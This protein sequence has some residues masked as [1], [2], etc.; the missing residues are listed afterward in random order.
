MDEVV[1]STEFGE[2]VD[3]ALHRNR[4]TRRWLMAELDVCGIHFTDTQLSNRCTGYIPFR[5]DE[6][7]AIEN[8]FRKNKIK[9]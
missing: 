1:N 8:V 4:K 9:L 6:V 7:D 2:K 3:A 5:Q